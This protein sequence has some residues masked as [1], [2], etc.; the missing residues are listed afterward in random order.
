MMFPAKIAAAENCAKSAEMAHRVRALWR[1]SLRWGESY[2]PLFLPG[3]ELGTREARPSEAEIYLLPG[4]T[5]GVLAR[6]DGNLSGSNAS[7]L[8]EIRLAN[9]TPKFTAPF[10]RSTIAATPVTCP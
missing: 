9:G 3:E 2:E 4:L 1:S 7:T 8:S 6:S 10:E 5:A